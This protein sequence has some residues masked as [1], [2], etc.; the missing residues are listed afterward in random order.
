M[1]RWRVSY[2]AAGENIPLGSRIISVCETY[3]RLLR[4]EKYP[5][6]QAVEF[7]Y[8][9]GNYLFDSKVVNAFVN[10]LAVYPLGSL[11]K[12]STGEVGLVVNVRKNQGPRPIVKVYFDS[13]GKPL[14]SPKDVDL[15][16]ERTL[17]IQRVL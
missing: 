10:N 8:G 7:L 11:V 3:D 16:K 14:P 15:G 1:E 12:L 17:F 6:Y 4:L 5:H 13:T 2:K 9:A